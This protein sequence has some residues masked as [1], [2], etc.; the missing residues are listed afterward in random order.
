MYRN[1]VKRSG[2]EK[3]LMAADSWNRFGND[4][5]N[6]PWVQRNNS[7]EDTEQS[8]NYVREHKA[9]IKMA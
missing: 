3:E 6:R 5:N 7:I 9:R 4:D 1:A 2:H 8:A